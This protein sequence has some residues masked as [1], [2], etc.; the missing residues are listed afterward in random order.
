MGGCLCRLRGGTLRLEGG[1][2]AEYLAGVWVEWEMA[3]VLEWVLRGMGE[4]LT[5]KVL[6]LFFRGRLEI[7]VC[8]G[9]RANKTWYA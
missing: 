8:K 6:F 1:K 2:A 3:R 9:D 5:E 7:S 4:P